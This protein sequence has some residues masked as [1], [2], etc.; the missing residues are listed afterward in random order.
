MTES[1]RIQGS[2]TTAWLNGTV[3]QNGQVNAQ[4]GGPG[5][6]GIGDKVKDALGWLGRQVLYSVPI[7]GPTLQ[8]AEFAR[9]AVS[10]GVNGANYLRDKLNGGAP[11]T[12]GVPS[13]DDRVKLE[14]GVLTINGTDAGENVS[15]TKDGDKITVNYQVYDDNNVLLGEGT[16]PSMPAK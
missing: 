10:F 7:I 16:I 8:T 13:I 2:Q 9:N 5:D 15:I 1:G 6:G 3:Q 14:N 11:E 12:G 4:N